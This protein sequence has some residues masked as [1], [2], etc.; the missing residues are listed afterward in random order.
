MDPRLLQY[1]NLELQ[2]LREMGAEFAQQFPKIA[3]R[4]GMNGLEVADPYVERLLE[5]VGFLAARVQLK[6]DAEFPRFT[7]SLLEIVLPHYLAP[8]PSM[9]V[10]QIKPEA[11]DPNL[12]RGY[13]DCPR[14]RRCIGQMGSDDATACE[15]RTAHDVTLF[16]IQVT[17]ATYFTFAPDLPLNTLAIGRRV[18]GG[19][20][21]RLKASGGLQFN[22]MALDR[23][24]FYL[25]GR[26]DVAN[27]LYELCLSS[28]LG[29]IVLPARRKPP[30]T[31]DALPGEHRPSGGLRG[32][33]GAP[34]GH[35]AV[36]SRLSPAG[37]VLLLSTALPVRRVARAVARALERSTPTRSRSSSCW[38]AAMPGSTASSTPRTS[39][40]SARRR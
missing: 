10:A 6:I 36:V 33:R 22:Q 13:T 34:A 8:I 5:G 28:A 27:K 18:K 14:V 4:L 17:S 29:V 40:C 9:L 39:R 7:Q 26:D 23:L 1:Y 15:F 24:P 20:R 19:L 31:L 12:G 32:R 37:R 25:A 30:A 11:D 38:G 3:A 16:P 2:H 35:G 21:I